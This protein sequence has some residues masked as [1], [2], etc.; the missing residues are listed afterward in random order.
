MAETSTSLLDRLRRQPDDSGWQQLV[1]L[2][3]PLIRGWLRQFPVWQ[4]D[5]DDVVQEV[6]TVVV[7]KLALFDRQ[8]SG[9]FRRW[10]RNITINCL[11]EWWRGQ[12]RQPLATGDSDFL[13]T[14]DQL[15]DPHS[16][17]SQRWDR[18][19]QRHVTDCL[20]AQIRPRFEETT[21]QAFQK[22]ALEGRSAAEVARELGMTPNA[23]FIAKSRVMTLLRQEGE[24]LLE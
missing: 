22:V 4:N 11:R 13:Q 21:W 7:R 3:T 2:Y 6:L 16:E 1:E 15:E 8:R 9:S 18:E 20:L 19:H 14:L 10:L 23:V 12:R 24:G 5:V 17:W